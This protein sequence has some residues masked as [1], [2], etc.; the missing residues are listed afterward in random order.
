MDS[1]PQQTPKKRHQ[2][3]ADGSGQPVKVEVEN[4]ISAGESVDAVAAQTD[5]LTTTVGDVNQNQASVAQNEPNVNHSE[6]DSGEIEPEGKP[7]WPEYFEPGR[8]EGLPN[9]VYHA[10]NGTSS[11]MVKDARVSLMYFDH[12]TYPKTI[13]KVRSPVLDMGTLCMHWRCSLTT[14]TKSQRRA[15]KSLKVRSPPPRRSAFIDEYNAKLPA[16]LSSDD[17]KPLLD[18]HNATL[19]AAFPLGASVDESMRH[20]TTPGRV[21]A[22]REWD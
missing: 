17:I 22:H 21:P 14:W 12:A 16:L 10:A 18:A 19:P 3:C 1:L 20:M 9:E 15:R 7:V 2:Q 4:A 11:T 13:Q 6:P 5:A 8:Y